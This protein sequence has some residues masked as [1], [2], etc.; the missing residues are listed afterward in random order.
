MD[1][2]SSTNTPDV[3]SIT[4]PSHKKDTPTGIY[5]I[6]TNYIKSDWH[7][8]IL[9]LRGVSLREI[10][11]LHT[12]FSK[13]RQVPHTCLL[14]SGVAPEESRYSQRPLHDKPG[15]FSGELEEKL[16]ALTKSVKQNSKGCLLVFSTK[17]RQ[18][19]KDNWNI[20]PGGR[21]DVVWIALCKI[22]MKLAM[23]KQSSSIGGSI[24]VLLLHSQLPKN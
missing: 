19:P 2:K 7:Y 23:D 16:P 8:I 6:P 10:S 21:V 4:W 22:G 3:Q 5:I 20:F 1:Q 12:Q 15:W 11:S 18:V 17:K 13:I 9:W 24:P 14:R